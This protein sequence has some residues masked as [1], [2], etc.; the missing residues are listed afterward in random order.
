VDP[1]AQLAELSLEEN[2]FAHIAAILRELKPY[3]K[4]IHVALETSLSPLAADQTD[5]RPSLRA[6]H[7]QTV[8]EILSGHG[9][10]EAASAIALQLY[11]TLYTGLLAFWAKDASPRQ[12][13]TLALMDQSLNMFVG[14]LTNSNKQELT[15]SREGEVN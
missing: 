4:Y 13:D 2:L 5:N 10:H 11:W 12:E 6:A 8:G 3:R 14:W 9:H 15:Q 1:S 7:L